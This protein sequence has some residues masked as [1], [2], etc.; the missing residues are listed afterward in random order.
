MLAFIFLKVSWHQK[1]DYFPA[2]YCICAMSKGYN[3]HTWVYFTSIQTWSITRRVSYTE[4]PQIRTAQAL[5]RQNKNKPRFCATNVVNNLSLSTRLL[6]TCGLL[7]C[8]TNDWNGTLVISPSAAPI[9]T[10]HA[11]DQVYWRVMNEF[12]LMINH[13]AAPIVTTHAHFRSIEESWKNSHW[14]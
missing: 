6:D 2:Y 9:V 3:L 8:T 11:Q 12:T 7:P 5:H 13:S 14:W 4:A 10:T 1:S